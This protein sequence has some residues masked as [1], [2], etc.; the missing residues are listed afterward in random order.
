MNQDA[1]GCWDTNKVLVPNNIHH[2]DQS[3]VFFSFPNDLKVDKAVDQGVWVLANNLPLYLYTGLDYSQVNVRILRADAKNAAKD[4][5]CD[6]TRR[7]GN[8]AWG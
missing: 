6:P 1:V 4:S 2:V 8:I 5:V 7:G 3:Q